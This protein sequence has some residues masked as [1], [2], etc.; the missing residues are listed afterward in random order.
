MNAKRKLFVATVAVWL[1]AGGL[2]AAVSRR[3]LQAVRA[4]CDARS[5]GRRLGRDPRGDRSGGPGREPRHNPGSL[6]GPTDATLAAR[7]RAAPRPEVASSLDRQETRAAS[8]AF[9]VRRGD[10]RGGRRRRALPEADRFR[11]D[12]PEHL[13]A[14]GPPAPAP[15]RVLHGRRSTASG[16][17]L[18]RVL[19]PGLAHR[20]CDV[21]GQKDARLFRRDGRNGKNAIIPNNR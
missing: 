9:T 14:V 19:C 10:A 11:N 15:A 1:T 13:P 16:R 8:T 2:A 20:R 18:P 4:A 21:V 3:A 6:P 7:P 5:R 12:G 17:G